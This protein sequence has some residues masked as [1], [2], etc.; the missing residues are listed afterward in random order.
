MA[1]LKHPDLTQPGLNSSIVETVGARFENGQLISS[2]LIGEIAL[3]YNATDSSAPPSTETIRLDNFSSLEKVAPNPAFVTATPDRS[4]EYTVDLSSLPRTQ[5]AFKYQIRV[6]ADTAPAPL[7]I[8]PALRVEATQC[9]VIVSYALN[10]AFNLQGQESITLSNVMLA[11]TIEGSKATGCQSKPV[12]SFIRD[13]SLI[14]WQLGDVTLSPGA[15]SE[16]LLARFATEA[17]ATGASVEA[18][19]EVTGSS[20]SSLAAW[21][22]ALGVSMLSSSADPFADADEHARAGGWKGVQG[23]RKLV[24]GSYVA[25]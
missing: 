18:R 15:G 19:W 6:D 16:K 2:S 4:G 25:K 8:K 10:P 14:Y 23:V 11:L 13:K 3:A 22:S 9:S 21:G 12:G 1:L 24:S 5:V 7:L 20:G 17:E